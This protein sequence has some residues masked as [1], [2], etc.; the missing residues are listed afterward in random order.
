MSPAAASAVD[1]LVSGESL[2]GRDAWVTG[3]GKGI[4]RAA[5]IALGRL[6]ARVHIV[7]RTASDLAETAELVADSGGAAVPHVCDV[8][9][10]DA[11]DALFQDRRVSVLVNCAGTNIPQLLDEISPET[12]DAALA[13]NVRATLFVTQAAVA[14][15]RAT[16]DGGSIVNVSSQMGHVGGPKRIVYCTSKWAVEGM[17]KA[18]AVE[19]APEGIR[20]NTVAPTFI[21]TPMTTKALGDPE[22]RSWVLGQ[23]P[24]GRLGTLEEVASAIAF[25]ASPASSLMTGSSVLVDGGWTAH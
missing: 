25:L 16:G 24:L 8:A 9:D 1:H 7:S 2:A 12:F 18:L 21:E 14:R 20:V 22:F 3:G 10:V 4:G 15:M 13:V 5:A 11:I 6:G 23:I 19:L 17:T